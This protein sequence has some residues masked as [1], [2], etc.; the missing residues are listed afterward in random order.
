MDY[1]SENGLLLILFQ[2]TINIFF[3]LSWIHK[4]DQ[5]LHIRKF[6]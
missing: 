2:E 6:Q 4:I 1:F 5:K 3:L